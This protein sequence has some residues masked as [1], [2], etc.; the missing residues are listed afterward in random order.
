MTCIVSEKMTKAEFKR[1]VHKQP[2]DTGRYGVRITDPSIVAPYTGAV[3]RHPDLLRDGGS[4][5]ITN[6]PRRSWFASVTRRGTVLMV[7]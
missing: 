1:L 4:I 6:H 2:I 7:A 5:T 3:E